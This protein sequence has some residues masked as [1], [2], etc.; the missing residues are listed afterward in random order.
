MREIGPEVKTALPFGRTFALPLTV[1]G[2]MGNPL[3]IAVMKAPSL[4]FLMLLS[5]DHRRSSRKMPGFVIIK[6]IQRAAVSD[7][8]FE[9]VLYIASILPMI[10][11]IVQPCE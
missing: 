8:L 7:Y 3:S 4:N 10:I 2:S 9:R 5:A 11:F 1:T 6:S